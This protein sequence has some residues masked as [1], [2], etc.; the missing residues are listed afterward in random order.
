MQEGVGDPERPIFGDEADE[1]G[2]DTIANECGS[3]RTH[4]HTH[5]ERH[6][7]GGKAMHR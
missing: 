4:L 5:R 1:T 6:L 3:P 2:D 7:L